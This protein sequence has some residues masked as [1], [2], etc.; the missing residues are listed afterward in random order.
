MEAER[1]AAQRAAR[2][3]R[4]ITGAVVAVVVIALLVLV[5]ALGGDDDGGE[6]TEDAAATT[7]TTAPEKPEVTIPETPPPTEL[8]STDITVGE[9][10][11]AQTGDTLRVHYVGKIYA[12]GEEFDSSYERDPIE[13]QLVSPGGVIEGWAQGL[14][15]VREGGRRQLVIPPDLGYG[16]QPSGD[17]PANST[18]VFVIDVL[19]V[20]KAEAPGG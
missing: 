7:T 20:E 10:E 8:Q 17:I 11:E 19:S 1:R 3:R 2:R 14:V 5:S 9:G 4:A 16:A 13:V 12:S 6:E 18:L 15:G